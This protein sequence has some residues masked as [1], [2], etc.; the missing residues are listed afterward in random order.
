ML[1]R[2]PL[3]GL[4]RRLQ[5]IIRA[6]MGEPMASSE[7]PRTLAS[8]IAVVRE[9]WSDPGPQP[10]TD[11]LPTLA[12]WIVSAFVALCCLA[13]TLYYKQPVFPLDDAYITLHNA[14]LFWG[15]V[16]PN[17]GN[18]SPLT[19]ATSVVHLVLVSLLFP[20]IGDWSSWVV[21]WLGVLAYGIGLLRLASVKGMTI[22]PALMLVGLGFSFGLVWFQL[23]NGLET[24]LAMACMLWIYAL[25][26]KAGTE[27]WLGLLLGCAPFIR[28]ELVA[29]SGLVWL[30]KTG[31]LVR[32]REF[33]TAGVLFLYSLLGAMPWL[34]VTLMKTGSPLPS[35]AGAKKAFFAEGAHAPEW[36]RVA[37]L[38]GVGLFWGRAGLLALALIP[39]LFKN[40]GRASLVFVLVFYF[41]YYESLPAAVHHNQFRYQFLVL[42]VLLFG[43]ALALG[44]RHRYVRVGSSVA[45]VL[46]LLGMLGFYRLELGKYAVSQDFTLTELEGVRSWVERNIP[47]DEAVLIHDAGYLAR[48]TD[49][50]LIDVVGLKTPKAI[51]LNELLTYPS[52][53]EK[54]AMAVEILALENRA[55]YLIMFDVWEGSFGIAK[56]LRER[57]WDVQKVRDERYQVYTL[58]PP[59][60]WAAATR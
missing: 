35:T 40:I 22:G 19:G 57:G 12:Y 60:G 20:L 4:C 6:K 10:T 34:L 38:N 41:A 32:S 3:V 58:V 55:K 13:V 53:G 39:L 50:R 52:R 8:D 37:L 44:D 42:P 56:G 5:E 30:I 24:G 17:Y 26:C 15:G 7:R 25:A 23:L 49:H 48:Y 59:G 29:F 1:L 31:A 45:G 16:D 27:R 14:S 18:V 9:K 46:A 21:Q 54:R 2:H 11:Q 47:K 33:G 51:G 43:A 28:P 36:R